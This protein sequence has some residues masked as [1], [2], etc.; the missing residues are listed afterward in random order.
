MKGGKKVVERTESSSSAK[1]P[2]KK[3]KGGT[4]LVDD[5][6][7]DE[8][9]FA[10]PDEQPSIAASTS[11]SAAQRASFTI[12]APPAS[13]SRAGKPRSLVG[14]SSRTVPSLTRVGS[15][16]VTE[17]LYR[18]EDLRDQVGPLLCSSFS[19]FDRMLLDRS[20]KWLERYGSAG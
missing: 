16:P 19:V 18:L 17:L 6:I 2:K 8:D 11:T 14:S 9:I 12:S 5:P 1:A 20:S 10:F 4:E 3:R 13:T 15:D 7:E